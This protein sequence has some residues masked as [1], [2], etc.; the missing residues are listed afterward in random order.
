MS[1]ENAELKARMTYNDQSM[2]EQITELQNSKEN[3]LS[4]QKKVLYEKIKSLTN[5]LEESNRLIKSYET[6]V[7]QLKNKN[8]KLEYNLK[9]LTESHSE[10]EKIINN[11]NSGLKTELEIREHNN[12]ELLKELEIKDLHIKSLEKLL[13]QQNPI[14][15]INI[16]NKEDNL[17]FNKNFKSSNVKNDI[18]NLINLE[19]DNINNKLITST[20]TFQKDDER[21]NELN[22]LMNNM[23][24][25]EMTYD[26]D[27]NEELRQLAKETN[28]MDENDINDI[29]INN[30]V[31]NETLRNQIMMS[32]NDEINSGNNTGKNNA[33]KIFGKIFNTNKK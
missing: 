23:K 29:N 18:N 10:L 15:A 8:N 1:K 9:M 22:K 31:F 24:N 20:S 25:K 3:E 32:K 5:L 21:E 27:M 12:N 13:I 30:Y 33:N 28:N 6:E 7:T 19:N 14:D 26:K 4:Q 2:T 11:D 17:A 16:K